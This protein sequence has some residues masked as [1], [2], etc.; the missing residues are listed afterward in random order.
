MLAPSLPAA[1]SLNEIFVAFRDWAQPVRVK[2]VKA[3]HHHSPDLHV[4]CGGKIA[5]IRHDIMCLW[6]E[7]EVVT[8]ADRILQMAAAGLR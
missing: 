7:P 4:W 6:L 1:K 2:Q 5:W 8:S 3:L